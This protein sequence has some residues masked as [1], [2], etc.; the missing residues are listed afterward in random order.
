M[1]QGGEGKEGWLEEETSGEKFSDKR[2]FKRFQTLLDKLWKG[3]G[4]SIPRACQDWADTKAAYRFLANNGVNE[5]MIF[6]GH[7]ESTRRRF[8]VAQGPILVLQ[9]TCEFSYQRERPEDIGWI[10]KTPIGGKKLNGKKTMLT[11][12]GILMHSSLAVTTE[13]LPLGLAAI[14]FWTRKK[15]KGCNALKGKINN[16]RIPIEKKESIR[17]LENLQQATELFQDPGRCIH[18][19]DR[20]SDIYELFCKAQELN[21][22]FLIRTCVDRLVEEGI[23]TVA[24]EMKQINVKG[25][26]TVEVRNQ[27]GRIEKVQ[28]EVRYQRMKILPPAGKKKRYPA[29]SLTVIEATE[30]REPVGRPKIHWK[31]LTDLPVDCPQQ[32]I[33]KLK[34]YAMRWKIETFHKILKSGCKAEESRLRTASRLANLISIFCI[35]SWRIFWM[36][37]LNRRAPTQEPRLALT[38]A[39]CHLLDRLVKDSTNTPQ[40]PSL[41][42]YLLKLAQLGG[43]LA[44]AKD[45]PPGNTVIWRGM[46]RLIDIQ[47]GFELNPNFCG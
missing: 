7:F 15:F 6:S 8:D 19:G 46:R 30:N 33:E 5:Q 25:L 27:K 24:H 2:L 32:A 41:A 18:I 20:E 23:H 21:T 13:G 17:W 22:H 16:T 14:K 9:D 37:M 3:M 10:G 35:V 38:Q 28:L 31:L 4:E 1:K 44:R 36:T 47:I 26:H 39:E 40:Q 12:C 43:Y 42:R 29:L 11:V 45:P 34:W